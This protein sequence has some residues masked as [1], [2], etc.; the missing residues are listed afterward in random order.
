M[1]YTARIITIAMALNGIVAAIA[2]T[3]LDKSRLK[4]EEI[5]KVAT[6]NLSKFVASDLDAQYHDA[7]LALQVV[8]DEYERQSLA[9]N[10]SGAAI[11][12]LIKRQLQLHPAL[13][14]IRI[15]D[16]GGETILGYEGL[17][18]P[19]GSNIAHR[20]Y[21]IQLRQ[22]PNAALV[23]SPPI[24]GKI[25]GKWGISFARRLNDREGTFKGI[26]FAFLD[27]AALQTKLAQLAPGGKTQVSVTD[28][29]FGLIAQFPAPPTG[30]DTVG[31]VLWSQG[32]K[33]SLAKGPDS[34]TYLDHVEGAEGVDRLYAYLRHTQ[35][36]FYVG[37]SISKDD[38]LGGWYNEVK[39]TGA[40][41]VAFA[42]ATCISAWLL[43]R[44]W[45]R[46]ERIEQTLKYERM[47]L[48]EV[49][50]SA[51]VGTWEWRVQTGE[52][53]F[54]ARWA[55][56]IGYRLEDLAPVNLS[57]W[58]HRMHPTDVEVAQGLLERLYRREL[59]FFEC[60]VRLRHQQGHWVWV[61][62]RGRIVDWA[63]D[64]QPLRMVGTSQDITD[65]KNAEERQVH[66][67]LDATPESMLM[68][69]PDGAIRFANQM[70]VASFGYA[71]AE[72]SGLNVD[73]LVPASMRDGHRHHR[74]AYLQNPVARAI[75]SEGKL[76]ATRKGGLEFPIEINLSH[77]AFHGESLVIASIKDITVRKRIEE[78]L[79][80]SHALLHELSEQVPGVFYQF[81]LSGNGI[82]SAP[83][84]S[85][86]LMDMFGLEPEH[87][88]ENAVAIFESVVQEDRPSF[89]ASVMKSAQTMQN[90]TGEFRVLLPDGSIR[91]REGHAHPIRQ[92]DGS[93]LW[94]GFVW[95]ATQRFEAASQ[96]QALNETLELRVRQRTQE[97]NAALH[98]AE[99]AM[100][101][102]GEFLTKMSHEIRTPLNAVLGMTYMALRSNLPSRE[103]GYLERIRVS[104]DHLLA[105][106]NDILDFSKID[107]GKL[108][109]EE[110]NFGLDPMLQGIIQL[111]ETKAHD[112]GLTLVLDVDANVPRHLCGDVLRLR[113]ILLNFIGN[114]IKFTHRGGVTVHVHHVHLLADEHDPSDLPTCMLR[115]EVQDTGIGLSDDQKSRL[116]QAFEQGD[117]S[118]TRKFGGTGLG[119]AI[120]RE[121]TLMMGG[122]IGVSS[123]EGLGSTFWFTA[124]LRHATGSMDEQTTLSDRQA[125]H[126]ARVLVVD[127]NEFNLDVA[128]ELLGDVGL[129]VSLATDGEQALACLHQHPFDW[130]LLDIQMPV[131][132]GIEVIRRIRANEQTSGICVIAMTANAFME[133]RQKYLHAGMNDV[134]TKPID[135]EH[136]YATLLKWLRA[137]LADPA[138]VTH[139]T[140]SVAPRTLPTY[141]AAIDFESLSVWDANMLHLTVGDDPATHRRLLNKFLVSA[142]TQVAAIMQAADGAIWDSAA[143][144]SHKLKSAART[145]G[146]MRLGAY[147]EALEK[148]GKAADTSPCKSLADAL[149]KTFVQTNSAISQ[150]LSS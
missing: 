14:S 116:F 79:Q 128:Q 144:I 147:C 20:P 8:A 41:W 97:L 132:D 31:K 100:K 135:P 112:K 104:G 22:D 65:R 15:T 136:L 106:I 3:S 42:L 74:E 19:P 57:T 91:W 131:M 35:Y 37:A 1:N 80:S 56:I 24:L 28:S 96:L 77:F 71:Q 33:Q 50:W 18:P 121:L 126:G 53:L 138:V 118:I 103:R 66:A 75:A 102:R 27:V 7:D 81:K 46:R 73:A 90:W 83:F 124:R 5:A 12:A 110:I 21:F 2:W 40:M 149:Q 43:V 148:S 88:T 78:Q 123:H 108:V 87:L 59:E 85:R 10:P 105:I 72:L 6:Q 61:L 86:G 133:D 134:I 32:L 55:D 52:V 101:S 99:I 107:A 11:N 115:F 25:S 98:T 146:A 64:G 47:R 44:A 60:E 120:S 70:A 13:I 94:H 54:N 82:F 130:V 67:V 62:D 117:N 122:E 48:G 63:T 26:I 17:R 36:P 114:A 89:T 139:L 150:L 23:I 4:F 127:D 125:L 29:Q 34:G 111:T 140:P 145:V 39:V 113:Q 30:Y 45:Q 142:R 109:L 95:D 84:A 51:H 129:Q 68:V 143:D 58:R 93:I 92:G 137:P 9:K 16:T 119:L 38:Y 141:A 76:R 49:I 69:A